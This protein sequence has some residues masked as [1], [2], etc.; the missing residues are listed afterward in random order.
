[1]AHACL[2]T[3]GAV[4]LAAQQPAT[5][6]VV[7]ATEPAGEAVSGARLLD[8]ARNTLGTTSAAGTATIDRPTDSLIVTVL[9]IGFHPR[10]SM[11]HHTAP[12]TVSIVLVPT[13]PSLADLVA[14]ET[15]SLIR[16]GASEWEVDGTAIAALPAAGEPDVFRTLRL[17]PAISFTSLLSARPLVRGIDADDAGFAIDGHEA[18]NLYHIGRFFAAFPAPAVGKLRTIAQPARLD[19]G[20]TTSGRIE[21][22]G[23]RWTPESRA[24]IQYGLG[25]WT[26]L[27]GWAADRHNGTLAF[28]TVEGSLAGL[29]DDGG[30]VGMTISDGYG[31]VAVDA[32]FPIRLTAFHSVDDITD[33]SPED[34]DPGNEAALSWGNTILG[35]FANPLNSADASL[36]IAG[37]WSTHHESG[38]GIPARET[39]VA[40]DNLV[41]RATL[42]IAGDIAVGTGGTRLEGGLEF[43]R[44]RVHNV[45]EA[46]QPDRIPEADLDTT[47]TEIGAHLGLA[48][49]VLGGH[50]RAGARLD[51][52]LDRS[53]LQPRLTWAG[54]IG[55]STW[56]SLGIGRTARLLHLISD[57]RSEPSIA[58]YDLW[59]PATDDV[60]AAI[61]DHF[62]AEVGW[63]SERSALR[64]G[65]YRA[66]GQGQHEFVPGE[67][68]VP[69]SP[70]IRDGRLRV[71]GLEGEWRITSRNGR[72]IQIASYV[73]QR[74]ERDW[75]DGWL[76]WNHDRTHT[77]RLHSIFRPTPRT[78]LSSS[79]EAGS[80]LPYTPFLRF[81]ST[82]Y[83]FGSENSARG[84]PGIRLD[85]AIERSF[86]GLFGTEMSLGLSV[87]NLALGD[88]SPREGEPRFP[89][90]MRNP[91]LSDAVPGGS[92]LFTLP[93]IPSLLLRVRF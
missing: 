81:D 69:G 61:A 13:A 72:W 57:A 46:E 78:A 62:S 82:S 66:T 44:R 3:T 77:L 59:W 34:V 64:L 1:M 73:L 75:G 23:L 71:H 4:P 32:G 86:A 67:A 42:R 40:I 26:G 68:V 31:R 41:R 47:G 14:L 29:A 21:I 22:E 54:P 85:L 27:T 35:V 74:S 87:T 93:P 89:A 11:L 18:I 6:I 70:L 51:R 52:F 25:A 83:V 5:R 55:A 9:A 36:L 12:D 10:T 65:V 84:R 43:G 92:Q 79:L 8:S 17:V 28:R 56:A 63:N 33:R 49:P 60:P 91:S 45:I 76:P 58:Y 16:S 30:D 2:L 80:G 39:S 38:M 53:E 20:R 15:S 7:R 37:T 88:Q 19:I 90:G 48:I 50:L 24:Q